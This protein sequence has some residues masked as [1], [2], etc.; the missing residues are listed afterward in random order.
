MPW[1]VPVIGA[2]VSLGTAAMNADAAKKKAAAQGQAGE[3][4]LGKMFYND[5]SMNNS[6]WIVTTSGSTANATAN[7][8]RTTTPTTNASAPSTVTVPGLGGGGGLD[9]NMLLILAAGVMLLLKK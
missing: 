6:G 2:V 8:D 3:M 4:D 7:T 9:M 5:Y 1:I